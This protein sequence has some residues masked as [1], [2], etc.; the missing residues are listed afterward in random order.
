MVKTQSN[1]KLSIIIPTLNEAAH[2]PLLLADLNLFQNNFELVLIDCGSKDLTIFIA[3]LAGARISEI[4]EANR[5]KQLQKGANLAKGEWLLFLHADSRLHNDWPENVTRIINTP[6]SKKNAW[7][8]DF[9]VNKRTIDFRL[10]ELAVSFRSSFFHRPYGDQGLLISKNL[11]KSIGGF[12]ELNIMEDLDLI[13]RLSKKVELRRIGLPLYTDTRKWQ[14]GNVLKQAVKNAIYRY[15]W[16][17]GYDIKLLSK[18]YYE[19]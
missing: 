16:K 3:K 7:F 18:N 5:G 13:I 1:P 9:K 19:N 8:F 2:L 14:K 15:K 11:Y 4:N 17:K 6:N 10:L 12:K